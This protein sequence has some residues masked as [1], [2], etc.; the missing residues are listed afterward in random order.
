MKRIYFLAAL[1][2]AAVTFVSVGV[3]AQ[4]TGTSETPTTSAT[5]SLTPMPALAPPPSGPQVEGFVFSLSVDKNRYTP[6]E[7]IVITLRMRNTSSL[8]RVLHGTTD[9]RFLGLTVRNRSGVVMPFT[10]YGKG[11]FGQGKTFGRRTWT[12]K[13]GEEHTF[14]AQLDRVYDLTVSDTYLVT[15]K[16]YVPK[17]AGDSSK[18]I[19]D[20]VNSRVKSG[21]GLPSTLPVPLQNAAYAPVTSNTVTF[22]R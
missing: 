6:N 12:F 1:F 15:S 17:L 10:R 22:R 14:T 9:E 8:T 18:R 4:T 5:P 19:E 3:M 16:R 13:P 11:I 20:F 2:V 21:K 7:P